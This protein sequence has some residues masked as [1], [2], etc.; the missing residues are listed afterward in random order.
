M[1][2][3]SLFVPGYIAFSFGPALRKSAGGWVANGPAYGIT[4]L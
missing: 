4:S 1:D 3:N 2:G